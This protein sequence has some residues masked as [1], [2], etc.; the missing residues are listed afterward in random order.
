MYTRIRSI[1]VVLSQGHK[2]DIF[3]NCS[4]TAV[5]WPPKLLTILR[6]IE[7]SVTLSVNKVSLKFCFNSTHRVLVVDAL[8]SKC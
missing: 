1:Y 7:L 4:R 3:I 6:P 5:A 8:R 2:A